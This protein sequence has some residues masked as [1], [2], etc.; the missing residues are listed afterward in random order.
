MPLYTAATV[1]DTPQRGLDTTVALTVDLEMLSNS[2]FPARTLCQTDKMHTG[3]KLC[4]GV[5][6]A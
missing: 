2:G 5:T 6:L 3:D 4:C 1:C